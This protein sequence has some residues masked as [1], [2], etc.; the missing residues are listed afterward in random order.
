MFEITNLKVSCENPHALFEATL[1]TTEDKDYLV[2]EDTLKAEC[3]RDFGLEGSN[4]FI[5]PT[6][7][8]K[9]GELLKAGSIFTVKIWMNQGEKVLGLLELKESLK[10]AILTNQLL[11]NVLEARFRSL[12]SLKGQAFQALVVKSSVAIGQALAS[13]SSLVLVSKSLGINLPELD[14]VSQERAGESS[15]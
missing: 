11:L 5:E 13:Y 8:L 3:L 1:E 14:G 7:L 6:K 15:E 9:D 10:T 4:A 12:K 2:I